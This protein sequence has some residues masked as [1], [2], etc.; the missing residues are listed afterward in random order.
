LGLIAT[1]FVFCIYAPNS[2]SA[3]NLPEHVIIK[4]DA[5]KFGKCSV[6]V[7]LKTKISEEQ[8]YQLARYIRNQSGREKYNPLFIE[9]YLPGMTVGSGAYATSNYNP[10]LEV[11]VMDFML[12]GNPPEKNASKAKAIFDRAKMQGNQ[13]RFH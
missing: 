6:T 2:Y 4:E 1:L 8:V 3:A 5:Y 10:E 11:N 7:L 9:Y 13:F 12:M